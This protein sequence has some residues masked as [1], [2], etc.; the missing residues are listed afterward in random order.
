MLA[1][2]DERVAMKLQWVLFQLQNIQAILKA[3]PNK[4][5]IPAQQVIRVILVRK[6][7]LAITVL[8]H[9]KK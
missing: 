1:F 2:K 9:T 7:T 6:V 8:I 5:E 3:K 4:R